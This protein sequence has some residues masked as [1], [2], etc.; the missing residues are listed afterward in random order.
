[1][2][3]HIKD[4]WINALKSGRYEQTKAYLYD[5]ERYC[6]LGVLTDMYVT[7][8]AFKDELLSYGES[9]IEHSDHKKNCLPSS[10]VLS[11]AQLP[12]DLAIE[13]AAMNDT[14]KTFE[15]IAEYIKEKA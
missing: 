7:R 3:E 5:G 4:D 15:Q 10:A 9:I 6:C 11:W 8:C 1:M 13:L 2:N 12:G 14:G